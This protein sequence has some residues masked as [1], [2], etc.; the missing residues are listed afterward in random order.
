MKMCWDNE[1][2][3]M[4]FSVFRKPHQALKY[5]DKN[6]THQATTFKSIANGVFTR[7]ARLTLKSAANQ[8][9][10]IDNIHPDH[11]EALFTADLAPPTDFPTFKEL[12]N[13]DKKR[14]NEPMKTKRSK[15]DQ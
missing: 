8:D 11:A 2:S 10:R 4:R 1:S 6:S 15:Q 12:W 3:Y 5:V 13:D 7:L 14:K 9:A